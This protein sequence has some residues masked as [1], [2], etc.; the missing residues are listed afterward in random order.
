MYP[1]IAPENFDNSRISSITNDQL[2][3]KIS[4]LLKQK[5]ISKYIT[6]KE[7]LLSLI[8]SHCEF[9]KISDDNENLEY[10]IPDNMTVFNIL[11]IPLNMTKKDVIDN[12][13]LINLQFNRLYKRGFYWVLSTTEKETVICMQNS[14]RDLY[15]EESKVKYDLVNKNQILKNMKE[16]VEKNLYQKD[17]KNLGIGGNNFKKKNTFT[18]GKMSDTDN[19]A[20]SWRKGSSDIKSSFDVNDRQGYKKNNYYNN[21]YNRGGYQKKRNRYNSDVGGQSYHNNYYE[22]NNNYYNNN[23]HYKNSMNN[24]NNNKDLE[25]DIS[26]LKYPIMIKNKYSFEDIKSFYNKICNDKLYPQSPEFL[27]TICNDIISN[28]QKT[29]VSLDELIESSKKLNK[30]NDNEK[31]NVNMKIPKVNPLSNLGKSTKNENFP[32]T[33]E[34]NAKEE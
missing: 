21:N 2:I 18:R 19:D 31:I 34:E 23:N 32:S 29:L 28:S 17:T 14:L 15:F 25:I 24:N 9:F 5:E 8:K 22:N 20:F 27:S 13:E 7:K 1:Y 33:V 6:S 16:I 3:I 11:N 12:I 30:E 26:N 10:N 4:D